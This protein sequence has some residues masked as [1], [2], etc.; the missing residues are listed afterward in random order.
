LR[1]THRAHLHV[2]YVSQN[3]L[4]FLPYV[5]L[6]YCFYNGGEVDLLAVGTES[7]SVIQVNLKL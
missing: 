3:K 5:R 7:L 2:L 1:F 4:S 6:N